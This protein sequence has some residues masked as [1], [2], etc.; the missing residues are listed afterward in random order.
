[1]TEGKKVGPSK[2][3]LGIL[4]RYHEIDHEGADRTLCV[5]NSWI[6]VGFLGLDHTGDYYEGAGGLSKLKHWPLSNQVDCYCE[7]LVRS[8]RGPLGWY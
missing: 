7:E 6:A 5:L 2:H 3:V 4:S 8:Q 1:M